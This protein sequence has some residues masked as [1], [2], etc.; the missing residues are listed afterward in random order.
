M[1]EGASFFS[2]SSELGYGEWESET[3]FAPKKPKCFVALRYDDFI[4]VFEPFSVAKC[5]LFHRFLLSL[6][7]VLR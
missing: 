1:K 5:W 7:P 2:Y 3:L 6:Q 4:G